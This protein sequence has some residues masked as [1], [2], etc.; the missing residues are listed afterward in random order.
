MQVPL[1]EWVE[2]LRREYA[3]EF[4]PGG[5][6]AVKI[7]VA[8]PERAG[9][10]LDAASEALASHGLLVARVDASQTRV[11]MIDQIF[12]AV[13]R[14]VDWDAL[15]VRWL[16]DRFAAQGYDLPG[17]GLPSLEECAQ[18]RGTRSA[19]VLAETQRWIAN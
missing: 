11:H 12:F 10:V 5:G 1:S 4:V 7:A 18:S 19:D 6:A 15:A 8:P 16:R 13:A 14:Q 9:T 2:L 3:A 17:S